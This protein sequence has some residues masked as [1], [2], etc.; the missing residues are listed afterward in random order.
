MTAKKEQAIAAEPAAK[1]SATGRRHVLSVILRVLGVVVILGVGGG[2]SAYWLM[3]RPAARRRPPKAEAAL[4]EVT[5]VRLGREKVIVQAMGAV[6]PAR[7]VKLAAQVG[8]KITA[9]SEDVIP[10]GRLAA[11]AEILQID[12]WDYL[13]AIEQ[14]DSDLTTA[15]SNLTRFRSALTKAENDLKIEMGRQS[16]AADE[17]ALLKEQV[18]VA[19]PDKD[20]LLR[21]PQLAIAQANVSAARANVSAAE[22]SVAAAGAALEKADLDLMRTTVLAPFNVSVQARHVEKGSIVNPSAALVSLVGTDQYWVRVTVPTDQLRWIRIP[23]R[24]GEAGS[25]VRIYDPTDW[26]GTEEP[27]GA[28]SRP[29]SRAAGKDK[30]PRPHRI[31]HVLRLLPNLETAGRMAQ[32]LVSVTDPLHLK[33]AA[34][35]HRRLVLDAYV[36]VEIVGRKMAR[37]FR[38]PRTALRDGSQ[39]WIL[40]KKNTLEIRTVRVVWSTKENVFV[41]EGLGAGDRLITTDLAGPVEGMVLRTAGSPSTRPAGKRRPGMPRDGGRE[42]RS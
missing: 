11:E 29:A 38:L 12:P 14:R 27:G 30:P 40:S 3:N 22:A 32:L 25:T 23:G 4:V 20:L 35:P 13:L 19:G 10:G 1:R 21:K 15:R 31:G 17:Y 26:G 8:G 9:V 16:M 24:N 28:A 7:E 37:V 5:R 2:V 33:K 34:P 39:V 36:N 6:I 18:D 42:A 41:T